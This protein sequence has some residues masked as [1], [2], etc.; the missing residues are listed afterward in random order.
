MKQGKRVKP[1]VL[2][3]YSLL[4]TRVY[5]EREKCTVTV[6]ALRTLKEFSNFRYEIIVQDSVENHTLTL[7][8]QGLRAPRQVIPGG[9]PAIFRKEFPDLIGKVDVVVAKHDGSTNTFTVDIGNDTVQI[10][11]SP[12]K[13]FLTMVTSQEEW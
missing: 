3:D 7:Q 12:A 1:V 6:V 11:K 2:F 5:K 8:V 13:K 10:L 4:I 9:G